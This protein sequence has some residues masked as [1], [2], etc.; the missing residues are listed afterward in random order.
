M[1]TRR[2]TLALGASATLG[3]LARA[4]GASASAKTRQGPTLRTRLFNFKAETSPDTQSEMIS[5]LRSFTKSPGVDSLLIGQNFIPTQFSSRFEWI[6]MIQF[7]DTAA[8]DAHTV[9]QDFDRAT[10]ALASHCRNAVQCDLHSSFPAKFA[11]GAGVK[12]RHTVMFDFK[13]DASPEAR[14]RN[15]A[16]IRTMGKLPMVQ[17]YFVER[18]V[19][20]MS[21]PTQM[22]WQVIGDFGSVDD[23]KAYSQAP[24]HLAIR[25][26]FTAHTSRVAFLDVE[27]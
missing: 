13:A 15:V 21:G 25:D 2:D 7:G 12:V 14:E 16:A 6:F 1:P 19:G 22:Q 3:A 17:R 27:L 23:Y 20:E 9:R 26:D 11:D 5:R 18:S 8:P 4:G 24:V 10:K